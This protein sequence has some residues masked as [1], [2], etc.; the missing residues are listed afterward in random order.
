MSAKCC[1]VVFANLHK[2]STSSCVSQYLEAAAQSEKLYNEDI[3]NLI[4]VGHRS[5]HVHFYHLHV[6]FIIRL[7]NLYLD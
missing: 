2:F 1:S 7:L 6:S 3:F 4:H 5:V